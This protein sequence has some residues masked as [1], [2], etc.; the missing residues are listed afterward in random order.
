MRSLLL[1]LLLKDSAP[2]SS[3][4]L[5]GVLSIVLLGLA[6]L[7]FALIVAGV[8]E[9]S[10]VSR[11]DELKDMNTPE[12]QMQRADYFYY[13]GGWLR[14]LNSRAA[15]DKALSSYEAVIA[16]FP[17]YVDLDKA[18]LIWGIVSTSRRLSAGISAALSWTTNHAAKRLHSETIA[19]R[20]TCR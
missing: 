17:H 12:A 2:R 1:Y 15:D 14:G 8:Q 6:W 13:K 19:K 7:P 5:V 18:Y 20:K 9:L 11:M 16:R 4:S 10:E 3:L